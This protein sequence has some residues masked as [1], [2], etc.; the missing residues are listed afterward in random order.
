ML[1]PLP[2]E[3]STTVPVM[4]TLPAK[5]VEPKEGLVIASDGFV[6]STITLTFI[7]SDHCLPA[8]SIA[9]ATIRY[10]PDVA[11]SSAILHDDQSPAAFGVAVW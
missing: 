8:L 4:G 9:L 2:P 3:L 10:V 5:T 1:T 6:A 7:E 11:T